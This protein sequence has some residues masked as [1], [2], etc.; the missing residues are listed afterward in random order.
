VR[1]FPETEI[2]REKPAVF[3]ARKRENRTKTG[4][5]TWPDT[6]VRVFT[7]KVGETKKPCGFVTI[8]IYIRWRRRIKNRKRKKE[9]EIK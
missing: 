4:N 6:K 5:K 8:Q 7:L 3:S 9:R 1:E 2:N